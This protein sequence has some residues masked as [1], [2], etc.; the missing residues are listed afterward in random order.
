MR[1]LPDITNLVLKRVT[2]SLIG[3]DELTKEE[4]RFLS[5]SAG[6]VLGEWW[7]RA[8]GE[9]GDTITVFRKVYEGELDRAVDHLVAG[10]EMTRSVARCD[11]AGATQALLRV[12]H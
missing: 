11:Y 4:Q 2:E 8:V 12:L 1:T 10:F 3:D 9:E 7:R 5:E 6:F